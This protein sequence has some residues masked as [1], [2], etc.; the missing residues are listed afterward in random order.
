[1]GLGKVREE[2]VLFD[3]VFWKKLVTLNYAVALFISNTY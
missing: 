3:V 1:M 2:S